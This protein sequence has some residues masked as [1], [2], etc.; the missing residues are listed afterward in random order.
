[1]DKLQALMDRRAKIFEEMKA[2]VDKGEESWNA[3]TKEKYAKMEADFDALTAQIQAMQKV[4]DFEDKLNTPTR[5]PISF[6]PS[7]VLV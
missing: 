3:E 6:I 1:M 2:L 7:V 5:E 4:R